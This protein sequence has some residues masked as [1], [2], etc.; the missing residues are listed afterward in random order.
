MEECIFCKIV[1]GEIPS[2]QIYEDQDFIVILDAFPHVEGQCL[3][4]S[5]NHIT[6]KFE[7]IPQQALLEGIKLAQKVARALVKA[8]DAERVVQVVEGL[9]VQQMHIKLFPVAEP[10]KFAL[11][12]LHEVY[13]AA[14]E[15]TLQKE[16]EKAKRKIEEFLEP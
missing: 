10:K 6:S 9:E 5:K 7:E 3:V 4:I 16:A 12:R 1:A 11:A 2:T 8:F 13:P 15:M 14:K